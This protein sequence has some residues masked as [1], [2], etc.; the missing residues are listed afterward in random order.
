[1][2]KLSNLINQSR[3]KILNAEKIRDGD[4]VLYW[5]QATQ[6][7][8][9]NHALEYSILKANRL[10]IPLLVYF[11]I[12]NSYPEANKRHYYFMLE[13]LKEVQSALEEKGIKIVIRRISPE[14]GAVEL[15]KSASLVVVDQGYTKI[16]KKW[17]NYVKENLK[18][19]LIQVESNVIV[20]VMVASPK[21]EYSAAT[22]RPK[23]RKVIDAFLVPLEHN[24]LE[25]D[26]LRLRF[27]SF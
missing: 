14:L 26:S 5:M 17:T 15:A 9:Y 18:C 7:T 12:T 1:M 25:K 24:V 27:S 13:G 22:F 6:R 23:I 20:P 8:E 11:G 10:N 16:E 19:P 4:F 2:E 21:E 3:I